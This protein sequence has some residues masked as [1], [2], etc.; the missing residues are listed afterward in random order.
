MNSEEV[1]SLTP[2]DD[3]N[4]DNFDISTTEE[5]SQHDSDTEPSE[6]GSSLA[7]SDPFASEE[8]DDESNYE[9][10]VSDSE[11]QEEPEESKE[12]PTIEECEKTVDDLFNQ[13]T[14]KE[15]QE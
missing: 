4:D 13:L 15:K 11:E 6:E 3:L 1:P 2:L 8:D 14:Q 7:Q 10:G 5:A 9:I 12:T